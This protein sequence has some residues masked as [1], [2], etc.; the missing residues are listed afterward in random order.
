VQS[1]CLALLV[2][3]ALFSSTV[4]LLLLFFIAMCVPAL[5]WITLGF[6]LFD[7]EDIINILAFG[8][9]RV[10]T[11]VFISLLHFWYTRSI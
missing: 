3:A 6:L 10:T 11:D 5:L 8:W 1:L 4:R 2:L 9:S 7:R